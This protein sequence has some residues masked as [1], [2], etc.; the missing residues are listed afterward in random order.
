[1]LRIFGIVRNMT[2]VS[3]RKLRDSSSHEM[4]KIERYSTIGYGLVP[5]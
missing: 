5:K 3:I 4:V 2:E 1:M